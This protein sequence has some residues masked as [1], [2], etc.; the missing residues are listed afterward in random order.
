MHQRQKHLSQ[1]TFHSRVVRLVLNDKLNYLP[2]NAVVISRRS[3]KYMQDR[4]KV[5]LDMKWILKNGKKYAR[6][7][8]EY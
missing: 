2:D 3:P 4:I 8:G 6:L 1:K 5:E 7:V